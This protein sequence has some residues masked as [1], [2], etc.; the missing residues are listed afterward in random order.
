MAVCLTGLSGVV[1]IVTLL[2]KFFTRGMLSVAAV[3]IG[4]I[5]GYIVAY[6][7]GMVN[8]GNI[9]KAASLA[10]PNPFHF[11]VEFTAAAIIGFCAMSFVS[12][13]ETLAMYPVLQKV[14][15]IVKLPTG[16]S[17]LQP[18]QMVLVQR[19]PGF[20][21]DYPIHHSVRMSGLLP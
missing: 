1:I 2:L 12:A 6:F 20:S 21:A 14:V 3:L 10:L 4:I 16:K 19:W 17:A 18:M 13:V 7:N 11:G 9:G 15:L 8:F 5:A